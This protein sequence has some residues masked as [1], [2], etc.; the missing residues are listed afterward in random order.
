L[1]RPLLR[2]VGAAALLV[3]FLTGFTPAVELLGRLLIPDRP[4]EPAEA[5]VILGAG[6]VAPGGGLTD[7]SLRATMEGV[8]L[9]HEGWAPLLVL[10]GGRGGRPRTEAQARADFARRAGVPTAAIV[11]AGP[12]HTTREEA[13]QVRALLEPRGV[14]KILLVVDGPGAARGMGVFERVGFEAVPAPWSQ[15]VTTDAT[16]ED[17]LTLLRSLAMEAIARLYYRLMGYV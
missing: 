7:S 13:V 11:I 3:F 1:S 5:I 8:N 15:S 10:S 9:F 16:P 12:A 4:A 6:G 17:R 2:G 14:R